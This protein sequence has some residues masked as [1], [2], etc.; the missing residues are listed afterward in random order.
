MAMCMAVFSCGQVTGSGIR[1]SSDCAL[2]MA[3]TMGAK[4]VPALAK[5]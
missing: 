1:V 2:A 4:S 5:K 3:S